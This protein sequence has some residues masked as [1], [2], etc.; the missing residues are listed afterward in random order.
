[1]AALIDWAATLA[2][3]PRRDLPRFVQKLPPVDNTDDDEE[4][5]DVDKD[6]VGTDVVGPTSASGTVVCGVVLDM[7]PSGSDPALEAL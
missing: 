6:P 2:V 4:G 7:M 1:M 3:V 5:D